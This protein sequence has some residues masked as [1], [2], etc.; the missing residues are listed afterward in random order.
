MF[1]I[2]LYE[3]PRLGRKELESVDVNNFVI[4]AEYEF[5]TSFEFSDSVHAE[6]E[7]SLGSE[8][9]YGDWHTNSWKLVSDGSVEGTKDQKGEELI[10][11][12]I[13]WGRFVETFD[14]ISNFFESNHLVTNETTGLHINLSFKDKRKTYEIDPLKLVLFSGEKHLKKMFPR[15]FSPDEHGKVF[16]YVSSITDQIERSIQD[17]MLSRD[18]THLN[19]V[20]DLVDK[21]V[22]ILNKQV[23]RAIPFDVPMWKEK[24]FTINIGKL[25][26]HGYIEFRVLGGKDYH[27]RKEEILN[28]VKRFMLLMSIASDK[29]AHR[30][31][32]IKKIVKLVNSSLSAKNYDPQK[33]EWDQII[34][35]KSQ[36]IEQRANEAFAKY[37]TLKK[38]FFRMVNAFEQNKEYGIRLLID[39]IDRFLYKLK[40]LGPAPQRLIAEYTKQN[41]VTKKELEEVFHE[42]YSGPDDVKDAIDDEYWVDEENYKI[43]TNNNLKDITSYIR[44]G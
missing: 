23:K 21:V 12:K 35:P 1:V 41:K 22:E 14:I 42:Y 37:P 33:D 34:K 5:L 28:E 36:T 20:P 3:G 8:I 39:F 27:K 43:D 7:T 24:H 16:D 2:D 10:T 25:E 4:G 32:Y 30:V 13:N 11:P 17:Y 9:T 31:E 6:L 44:V 38:N 26:T 40:G 15:V 19:G 29:N 18:T